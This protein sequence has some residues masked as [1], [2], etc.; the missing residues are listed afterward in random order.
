MKDR[1]AAYRYESSNGLKASN[2]LEFLAQGGTDEKSIRELAEDILNYVIARRDCADFRAAYLTRVLYSFGHRLPED[3]YSEIKAALLDF[4]YEDCGGHSMCTWTENHR[5]YAAG[6]EYLLAQ[7]FRDAVFGDGKGYAYHNLHSAKE[8]HEG[9]D[10]MLKYGFSEWGS[11]NYYSE[12]MAG[13][14]NLVQYVESESIRKKARKA[15]L[16]MCY[17]L[18]SQTFY[19]GGYVYNPAC[20]RAYADN[21][22]SSKI[23][24]YMEVQIRAMLGEKVTRYKEKECCM[25][26]LL[27][28]KESDGKPFFKIPAA[29]IN[30]LDKE[31]RE[32]ALVQGVDID[33]YKQ[34]GLASYSFKN[35]RFA[36]KAGAF[37]DYR[38]ICRSMRYIRETG[39]VENG[40]LKS[41]KPFARPLLYR[42]GILKAIKRMIPSFFDGA[43][44]EKGRVYT[45][46]KRDYSISAAFDYRV[47]QVLFQQNSL[48]VNLSYAISLFVTNPYSEPSKTGSP[49]YWL[50]SGIAPRAVAYKNFA[51]CMFDLKKA[52]RNL[53]YTHLF[54]PV[55]LFD[56]T[57]ISGLAD[58]ILFGRTGNVNVCVRTNPGVLFLPE[59]DSLAED[60]AMYQD[61]KIKPGYFNGE[62]DLINMAPE[63]H[64][65]VFEVDDTLGFEEFKEQAG[66]RKF[67]FT[68]EDSALFYSLYDCR[69][70]YEGPFMVG[71]KEFIPDFKRPGEYLGNRM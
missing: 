36:F 60:A 66:Q 18:L 28:E 32:I 43:A 41:L 48:A 22:T 13:L 5:L 59:E 57:D 45:Y 33:E 1:S 9:L 26:M 17:D 47:G 39:L 42:T 52:K 2:L 19:N 14:A 71:K 53:K 56:E 61:E 70:E 37:S 16:M 12:S 23:G 20:G 65:Y 25:V 6:T 64:Y 15:L 58:G 67:E 10:E 27:A 55:G 50:G 69:L 63:L 34:E 7:K 30:L 24:N 29:W 54:F 38:V 21:K 11:N 46:L 49:G 40:M 8:L 68:E 4:P 44:M 62:Y 3:I 35:V 51:A 31:E